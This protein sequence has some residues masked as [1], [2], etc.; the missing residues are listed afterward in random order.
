MSFRFSADGSTHGVVASGRIFV[1]ACFDKTSCASVLLGHPISMS[2]AV[3]LR[4]EACLV[5]GLADSLGSRFVSRI[6][7]FDQDIVVVK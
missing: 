4:V 7:L 2:V 6:E 1:T 5:L 3:A